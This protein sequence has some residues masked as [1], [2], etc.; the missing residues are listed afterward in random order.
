M[1][2]AFLERESWCL[3]YLWDANNID[4]WQVAVISWSLMKVATHILISLNH[5]G[6]PWIYFR[7]IRDVFTHLPIYI[8]T[9]RHK[10][11]KLNSLYIRLTMYLITLFPRQFNAMHVHDLLFYDYCNSLLDDI[12]ENF[13]IVQHVFYS[14]M[15]LPVLIV[16]LHF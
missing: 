11:Y 5:L 14:T 9:S 12:P 15:S 4:A 1:L 13:R 7:F 6:T 8:V 2:E 3:Q 10:C 16:L